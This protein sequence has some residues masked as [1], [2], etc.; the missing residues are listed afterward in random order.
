[1]HSLRSALRATLLCALISTVLSGCASPPNAAQ[2]QP[3]R[4]PRPTPL[5][6]AILG[7]LA[8]HVTSGAAVVAGLRADLAKRDDEVVLMRT[9]MDVDRKLLAP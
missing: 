6:A 7:A 5:P 1:M 9:Q 3:G 2:P 8:Q 4:K